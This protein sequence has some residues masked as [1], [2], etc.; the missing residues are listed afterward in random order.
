MHTPQNIAF[1]LDMAPQRTFFFLL[2]FLIQTWAEKGNTEM[3]D[4]KLEQAQDNGKMN[5]AADVWTELKELRDT[6]TELRTDQSYSTL[7]IEKLEEEKTG[8]VAEV[9][10]LKKQMRG[11]K[12]LIILIKTAV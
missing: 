11:C 12:I 5:I 6:V 10:E 7:K 9:E 2:F 4:M 3:V 1:S 8:L